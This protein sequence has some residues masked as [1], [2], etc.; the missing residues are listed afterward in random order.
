MKPSNRIYSPIYNWQNVINKNTNITYNIHQCIQAIFRNGA[1]F[2]T[3]CWGG[4]NMIFY[5]KLPGVWFIYI[6]VLIESISFRE[7]LDVSF[8]QKSWKN[9]VIWPRF[10]V[11]V[12]SLYST[13]KHVSCLTENT[14]DKSLYSE[15]IGN[16]T[17]LNKHHNA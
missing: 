14:K 10:S 16:M 8:Q 11:R 6:E 13:E 17:I 2:H 1:S 15:K 9:D 4:K 5:S 3:I 7:N 12:V